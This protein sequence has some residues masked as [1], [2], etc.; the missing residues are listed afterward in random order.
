MNLKVL[1]N[2]ADAATFPHRGKRIY[3]EQMR[4]FT[5]AQRRRCRHLPAPE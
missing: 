4:A 2:N 3:D 5:L 1:S